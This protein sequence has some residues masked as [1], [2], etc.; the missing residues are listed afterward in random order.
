MHEENPVNRRHGGRMLNNKRGFSLV[1][2]LVV[3]AIFGIV[4]TVVLDLYVNVMRSTVSSEE[5]V[6]VQQGMR[7]ALD[8]I[9]SDIQMAGF[10][11]PTNAPIVT[12][13]NDNLSFEVSSSFY[14]FARVTEEVLFSSANTSKLFP[15]SNLTMA[16]LFRVDNFVRIVNPADGCQPSAANCGDRD[17]TAPLFQISSVGTDATAPT[18]TLKRVAG[19]ATADV[20][21]SAGSMIVR[22][23][24]PSE[25]RTYPNVVTYLLEAD[26]ASADPNIMVL[27]RLP[28]TG[29]AALSATN[30]DTSERILATNIS[31][32]RFEYLM[33]DGTIESAVV[34]AQRA[35]IVGVRIFLTG[36]TETAKTRG[37]K[38]RE[39][40]TTVKIR[41]I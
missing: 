14:S 4:S 10:L 23:P 33:D 16:N 11:V 19:E 40:Q 5:V 21:V 15:V 13:A 28:R 29:I 37:S 17:G 6:E 26:P 2:L 36:L 1:E 38:T 20:R 18:L 27:S 12:A 3:V 7:M 35:N 24:A 30:R 8:R 22:V 41:N 31:G 25:D 34:G 9:A 32:L 39:L